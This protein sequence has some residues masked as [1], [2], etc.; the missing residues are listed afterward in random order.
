MIWKKKKN[1]YDIKKYEREIKEFSNY[2]N[3]Y[4]FYNELYEKVKFHYIE[5]I[6]RGTIDIKIEK[7]RLESYMGKHLSM[8]M[9]FILY[10]FIAIFGGI[11][12][13]TIQEA[14]KIFKY[15][16]PPI[17]TIILFIVLAVIIYVV[18]KNVKKDKPKDVI[19]FVSLKVLEDIEKE[20]VVL[21]ELE[22]IRNHD[23]VAATLDDKGVKVNNFL[24]GVLDFIKV[25]SSLKNRIC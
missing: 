19:A 13:V 9:N 23:E 4:S 3:E 21:K 14:V 11:F 15:S 12:T 1:K 18:D 8:S 5:K 7:I 2:N 17:N 20:Y 24:V 25:L 10:Y 6:E 16:S 22:N